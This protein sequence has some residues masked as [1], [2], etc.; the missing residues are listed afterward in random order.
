MGYKKLSTQLHR[1]INEMEK[2]SCNMIGTFYDSGSIYIWSDF[3]VM[4][5]P[6]D[7][8]AD[9]ISTDIKPYLED[10]AELERLSAQGCGVT[11]QISEGGRVIQSENGK[12]IVKLF[13]RYIDGNIDKLHDSGIDY[14]TFTPVICGGDPVKYHYYANSDYT[15]AINPD[16]YRAVM[17]VYEASYITPETR[18]SKP[19][20]PIMYR[21]GDINIMVMPC[22][23]G[24]NA[25]ENW[26]PTQYAR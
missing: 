5:M 8:Y 4:K 16:I 26:L 18:G 2:Q 21:G 13:N 6:G 7:M 25:L 22:R 19:I 17:G 20:N 11:L 14:D 1:L 23:T 15:V 10:I 12:S 3:N 9:N 24:G